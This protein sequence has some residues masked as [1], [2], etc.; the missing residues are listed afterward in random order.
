MS[1]AVLPLRDYQAATI[2]ALR[3]DWAAGHRRLAAVLPTGAG[4]TVI[5]AHLVRQMADIGARVL[6]LAHR[7]ELIQAA[8]D[9]LHSVGPHLRIGV[10]KGSRREVHGRD[11]VVAS[12]QSARSDLS[13]RLL[14]RAG[15]GLVIV[16][17]C[18]HTPASSYMKIL[19]AL[20]CFAEDGGGAL[21]AGFTATLMRS[22]GVALGEVFEKISHRVD[23]VDLIRRGYLLNAR[24]KRISIDGLDLRKVARTAG[25]YRAGALGQ[26]MSAAMAPEAVARSY[27]EHAPGRPG[28]VFWPTVELAYQ[29]AEA[30][31]SAGISSVAVDGNTDPDVRTGAIEAMRNGNVQVGH[32]AMLW[33]EGV[34]VPE[35]EVAVI[36]RPTAS[37]VLY[38]QMVG[39]V[40]RPNPRR[41]DVDTA[42]VLDVVGVTG[43]HKI[44]TLADL[45]GGQ[46]IEELDDDD[47][48][49]YEDEGLTL[50]ELPA[51][52]EPTDGPEIELVDGELVAEDVD[53][54]GASRHRWLQTE[55][56]VWFLPAGDELLFLAPNG[57]PDRWDVCQVPA[58]G[59][60]GRWLAQDVDMAYAMAWAESALDEL[61]AGALTRRASS[62]RSRRVS[63]GQVRRGQHVG[64]DVSVFTTQGEAADAISRRIATQRLDHLPLVAGVTR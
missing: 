27:H 32:N 22:D 40:L 57:Q 4:K 55:R 11:V 19:R 34:D 31:R 38:T 59:L 1:A 13:L 33:T 51:D 6:V 2:D 42:L 10:L 36:A 16:D 17:E 25:D 48:L 64:I 8:V 47:L 53:L 21:L 45:S 41:P 15:I 62:W 52:D 54:F 26:A 44:A 39:R 46:I 14:A 18:H 35:W 5:F 63:Q 50:D 43:K 9:K 60:G 29:G 28:V 24:G 58:E 30:F 49:S 20:G 56:G 61:E 7:D 12:V 3:R 23:I 37:P